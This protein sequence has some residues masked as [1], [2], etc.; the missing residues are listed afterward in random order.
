MSWSGQGSGALVQPRGRGLRPRPARVSRVARGRG[1]RSRRF[2]ARF[3]GRRGRL[4]YRQADRCPRRAWPSRRGCR[5]GARAGR[6]RAA[7]PAGDAPVRFH[8]PVRDVELP[9]APSMELSRQRRSTGSPAVGC[10]RRAVL[11][12][13][14]CFASSARLRQSSSSTGLPAASRGAARAATGVRSDQ[15][16]GRRRARPKKS[17]N[18][19]R[20]S[21]SATRGRAAELFGDVGHGLPIRSCWRTAE[22]LLGLMG[23]LAYL[24]LGQGSGRCSRSDCADVEDRGSYRTTT[25]ATC[26]RADAPLA[27][28]RRPAVE[29]CARVR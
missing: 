15:T 17:P 20:G 14:V 8:I 13:A 11:P 22:E 10:R 19:G 4:R 12:R 16:L 6:G 18:C 21:R 7:P 2:G 25:F 29:R 1:L 23:P 26:H 3:A 24:R 28:G 9:L 27:D 5:S